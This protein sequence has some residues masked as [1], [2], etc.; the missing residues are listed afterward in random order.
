MLF[1]ANR[2]RKESVVL[3]NRTAGQASL[4]GGLE[5]GQRV[6]LWPNQQ[7]RPSDFPSSEWCNKVCLNPP[8]VLMAAKLRPFGHKAI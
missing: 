8:S 5:G 4:E 2:G 6:K 7:P 1:G 3:R